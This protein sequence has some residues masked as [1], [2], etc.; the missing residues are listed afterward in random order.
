MLLLTIGK[1]F[2]MRIANIKGNSS[3]GAI[4]VVMSPKDSKKGIC[5]VVPI[6]E[7]YKGAITATTKLDNKVYTPMV[8]KLPPNNTAI[9]TADVA[10]GVSIVTKAPSA[11]VRLKGL[12][13]K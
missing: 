12:I 10:V 5:I 11:I 13:I 8:V 6:N 9:T 4:F 3:K 2:L 7:K 1:N